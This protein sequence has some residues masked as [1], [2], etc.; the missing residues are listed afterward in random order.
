LAPLAAGAVVAALLLAVPLVWAV[1]HAGGG[2]SA[3]SSAAR[4]G[5]PAR[6]HDGTTGN[7]MI[8]EPDG[9]KAPAG[10]GRRGTRATAGPSAA[11]PRPPAAT[12]PQGA[13]PTGGTASHPA[14]GGPP[15]T[16]GA[17]TRANPYNPEQVCASGGHGSGYYRQ[18]SSTFTGGTVYQLY[19][20]AGYNCLVTLKT[21]HVG[22]KTK[23]WAT[24]TRKDGQSATDNGAYAYYAGPVFLYAKG[25]C[26]KYQGG[27]GGATA[28]AP[29]GN[30]G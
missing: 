21:T 1:V 19:S 18:R 15:A 28:S 27:A 12:A 13:A 2:G 24:L 22:E 25:Q 11:A 14:T 6:G 23:A 8:G 16:A 17:T 26:V 30:C 7:T 3:G 9:R 10:I 29:W 20:S 5:S 4:S